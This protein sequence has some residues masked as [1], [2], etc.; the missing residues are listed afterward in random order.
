MVL[1]GF[2]GAFTGPV[3]GLSTPRVGGQFREPF[4]PFWLVLGPLK[5]LSV[6]PTPLPPTHPPNWPTGFPGEAFG[7]GEEASHT[8]WP[9]GVG[10]LR[11]PSPSATE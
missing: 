7:E 5:V 6:R 4:G 9:Q 10:G 1:C 2:L 11:G 8:P 3:P